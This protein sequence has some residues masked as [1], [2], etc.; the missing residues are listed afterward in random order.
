M[1]EKGKNPDRLKLKQKKGTWKRFVKLFHKCHLP[2]VWVA[3]CFILSIGIVNFGINETDYTAQLFA[4]DTSV[5]LLTKL[6]AVLIINML[7][8][9][10]IV[11]VEAITSVRINRNMRGVLLDK[12]MHLPM[13]Y[14]KDENPRET[15]YRIVQNAT[16]I[17][18]TVMVV[19]MP[20]IT[21]DTPRLLCLEKCFNMTGDFQSFFW[22]LYRCKY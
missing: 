3:I 19:I 14:F 1:I 21:P 5:A 6:V 16:V 15:I 11:F 8:S 18:S 17:D 2:W 13:R 20:L 7:G 22:R 12:V 9:S 10:L 4:G